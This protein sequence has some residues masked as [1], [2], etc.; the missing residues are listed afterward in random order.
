MT[1]EVKSPKFLAEVR[2]R[3]AMLQ[4]LRAVQGPDYT[5]RSASPANGSN[6]AEVG[7]RDHPLKAD[8]S[9]PCRSQF[10]L[11]SAT[12]SVRPVSQ[13]ARSKSTCCLM[14]RVWLVALQWPEAA[15]LARSDWGLSCR[16]RNNLALTDGPG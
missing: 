12:N 14:I 5:T 1:Y 3:T 10:S 6:P 13:Q 8:H 4:L 9:L 15:E 2:D 11:H 16:T 7:K